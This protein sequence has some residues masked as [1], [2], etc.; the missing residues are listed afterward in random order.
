MLLLV[1]E[2]ELSLAV[3]PFNNH[4]LTHACLVS[5]PISNTSCGTST[6]IRS[7]AAVKTSELDV[8]SSPAVL[9]VEPPAMRTS[10]LDPMRDQ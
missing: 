4:V 1:T 3:A 10:R 7:A 2:F 8:L 6:N 9:E 5:N